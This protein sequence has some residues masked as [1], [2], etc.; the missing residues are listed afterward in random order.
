M[1]NPCANEELLEQIVAD[2]IRTEIGWKS[3]LKESEILDMRQS[4][5]RRIQ[6]RLYGI[7]TMYCSPEVFTYI[8]SYVKNSTVP[9]AGTIAWIKAKELCDVNTD[10]TKV[11]TISAAMR[12]LTSLRDNPKNA[13]LV[14]KDLQKAAE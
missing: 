11:S 2:L 13:P 5:M 10:V 14:M 8:R 6:A 1:V 4:M 12:Q 9:N 7:I 3:N